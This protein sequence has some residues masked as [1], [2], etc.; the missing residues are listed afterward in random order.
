MIAR[1]GVGWSHSH[2]HTYP[3]FL[4]SAAVTNG[5]VLASFDSVPGN[6]AC[7]STLFK[8]GSTF[9]CTVEAA[10]AVMEVVSGSVSAGTEGALLHTLA[11]GGGATLGAPQLSRRIILCTSSF[12]SGGRAHRFSVELLVIE[13]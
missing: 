8:L 7:C 11:L 2:F 9:T 5:V 3:G 1:R 4:Q 13:W 6:F 10:V 12:S